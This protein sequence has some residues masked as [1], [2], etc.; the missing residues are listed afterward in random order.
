[1]FINGVFHREWWDVE[2]FVAALESAEGA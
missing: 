2:V 1:M